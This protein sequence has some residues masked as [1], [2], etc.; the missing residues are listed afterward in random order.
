MNAEEAFRHLRKGRVLRLTKINHRRER[1]YNRWKKQHEFRDERAGW[2]WTPYPTPESA[3][4][5]KE[6]GAYALVGLSKY[7]GRLVRPRTTITPEAAA[8][9]DVLAKT[10]QPPEL[11]AL[12]VN[13]AKELEV[14]DEVRT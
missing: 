7:E 8:A 5:D 2:V 3:D 11:A 6:P 4:L 1:R 13:A 10:L 12:L 9:L 14:S